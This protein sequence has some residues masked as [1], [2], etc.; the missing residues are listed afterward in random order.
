[1]IYHLPI[2]SEGSGT[3]SLVATPISDTGGGAAGLTLKLLASLWAI[4]RWTAISSALR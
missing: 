1:M 2:S 3:F 4:A